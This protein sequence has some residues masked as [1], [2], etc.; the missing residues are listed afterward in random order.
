[1]S[2]AQAFKTQEQPIPEIDGKLNINTHNKV[3]LS[4]YGDEV[5]IL[6]KEV[7]YSISFFKHNFF[8]LF[9]EVIQITCCVS[10]VWTIY[11][12]CLLLI[13]YGQVLQQTKVH[14]FAQSTLNLTVLP[15]ETAHCFAT[16]VDSMFCP[17]VTNIELHVTRNPS[18]NHK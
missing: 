9:F 6:Q 4:E 5:I 16:L 1:V 8:T 10:P 17:N 11:M 18:N 13:L 3:S 2:F 12:S 14:K 15:Y 7:E